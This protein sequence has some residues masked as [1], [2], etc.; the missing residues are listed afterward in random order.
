MIRRFLKDFKSF[1]MQGNVINLAVGVM[2]GGAFGKIVTSLVN[3]IFMPVIGF[4]TG[5]VNSS[6]SDISGLF[7]ALDGKT[8]Q[9]AQQAAEN[10]VGTLNYG[11]FLS[12][13]VDFLLMAFCIYLFVR[14]VN[15]LMPKA[16]ETAK[17]PSRK[18]PFCMMEIDDAATRCPHCTSRLDV[19]EKTA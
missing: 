1:A 18:C 17:P 4:L 16:K 6:F 11:A 3:D 2:I 8:Y 5:G 10:K 12:N 13:I 14:L 15:K 9:T 7:I 19:E